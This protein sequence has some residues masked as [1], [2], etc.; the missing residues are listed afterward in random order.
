MDALSSV[1]RIVD[2][3]GACLQWEIGEDLLDIDFATTL[4]HPNLTHTFDFLG[5]AEPV[6]DV[7]TFPVVSKEE[8]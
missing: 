2:P 7:F 4:I 5:L 6:G 8:E 1:C 3:Y